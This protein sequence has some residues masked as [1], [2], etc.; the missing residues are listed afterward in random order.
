LKNEN[1]GFRTAIKMEMKPFLIFRNRHLNVSLIYT[2]NLRS[3]SKYSCA[4]IG[5][6]AIDRD[7]A[8]S[9]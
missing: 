5:V 9:L 3:I 4:S 7:L 6:L 1:V 2:K 8:K